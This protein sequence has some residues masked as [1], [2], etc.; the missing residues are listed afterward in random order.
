[1]S[2]SH[3]CWGGGTDRRRHLRLPVLPAPGGVGIMALMIQSFDAFPV[4]HRHF[5]SK[6]M[7]RAAAALVI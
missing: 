6:G 5:R 2:G 1:M 7:P 4:N 3:R